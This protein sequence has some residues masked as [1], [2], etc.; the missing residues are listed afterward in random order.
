MERK[1]YELIIHDHDRDLWV[2][3]VGWVDVP[4]SG[5]GDSRCPSAV[6][7]STYL[8]MLGLKLIPVSKRGYLN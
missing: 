8:S 4:D 3:T 1:G 5:C 2:T 6:D 7:I